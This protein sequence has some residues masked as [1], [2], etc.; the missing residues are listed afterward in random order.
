VTT[1][2]LGLRSVDVISQTST[3]M[4]SHVRSEE[5]AVAALKLLKQTVRDPPL[6][7]QRE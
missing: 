4:Q 2:E 5:V 7:R 3:I 6:P 1:E